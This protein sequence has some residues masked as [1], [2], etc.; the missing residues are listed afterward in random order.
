MKNIF[1][2]FAL[3]AAAV[4][5]L[6]VLAGSCVDEP[7]K[8]ELTSGKPTVY[9]VRPMNVEKADSLLSG[10]YMGNG[11]CIVGDNL[12]SV[13]KLF[14]NDQEAVLNNSYITDNTILVNVPNEIP[15][16]V[17]DNMYLITQAADTVTYS[18]KVLVPGPVIN[19]MSC[20]YAPYGEIATLYGDYFVDDPNVPLKVFV[21]E[22]E[23]VVK[24]ISKGAI[25]FVTPNVD[26]QPIKVTNIYGEATSVFHYRDARGLL[27]NFDT[28]PHPSYHG[29]HTP[30]ILGPDDTSLDGKYLSLG[31]GAQTMAA[32]GGT[33]D[34]S[35]FCMEYWPGDW[36]DPVTYAASPRLTDFADFSDWQN[37][38]LKFE[39]CIPSSNPW[40]AGSLQL[41]VGGVDKITGGAA[42]AIDIDGNTTA[43][44]NNKF[45]DGG[46]LPRGLYSPWA[47]T[48]SFDTGG[49][50]ITVTI[51]YSNFIYTDQGG[52]SAGVLTAADFTSLTLF[53]FRG[54]LKGTE[55]NPIIK[56]DNI[57]A[58]PNK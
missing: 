4:M 15:G 53:L 8:F 34:D 46:A 11:I 22:T 26:D 21:G 47:T 57:R 38:A 50:W 56:I 5:T 32:D 13:Y 44:A 48:G 31:T 6:G 42:G 58:V 25:T 19:S 2:K 1:A 35:N 36:D 23:A 18:F 40:M 9:Y 12:R 30:N 41:I 16:E 10:A 17:S 33:W 51:P 37:M 27:F 7:D 20:E 24:S 43:G 39:M 28:D 54:G 3:Y 14:F 52:E 45:F 29:W 55:C 49:K